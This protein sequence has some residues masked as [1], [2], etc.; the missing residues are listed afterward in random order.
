LLDDVQ[1]DGIIDVNDQFYGTCRSFA[2]SSTKAILVKYGQSVDESNFFVIYLKLKWSQ[3]LG[4]IEP[5]DFYIPSH[6]TKSMQSIMAKEGEQVKEAAMEYY[7][8]TEGTP[9]QQIIKNYGEQ[10]AQIG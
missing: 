4:Q 1:I 9:Y 6:N 5:V 3:H 2:D 7:K 8:S 10:G